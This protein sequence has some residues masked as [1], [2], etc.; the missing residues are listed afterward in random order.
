MNC[1]VQNG[2]EKKTHWHCLSH[3]ALTSELQPDSEMVVYTNTELCNLD[4]WTV[5]VGIELEV[6][7]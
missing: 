1:D 2:K 3:I 6:C 7:Y 4:Y 5:S